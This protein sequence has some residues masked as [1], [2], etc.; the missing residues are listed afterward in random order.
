VRAVDP[1]K[2]AVMGMSCGGHQ[3]LEASLDP[4]VT[5]SVIMNS[6]LPVEIGGRPLEVDIGK[7]ILAKLHAPIAY[8]LG[9]RKDS[10]YS[11]AVD[12]FARINTIPAV[13]ANYEVGH[14][15]TYTRPNGGEFGK[16]AVAW[17]KWQL[18]RDEQAGRMYSGPSCGL[19]TDANWELEKKGIPYWNFMH[20]S[21]M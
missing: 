10:A 2:F 1:S 8:I 18:K 16:I 19:C 7:E 6:G 9:G 11:A 4:R 15:G 17:L 21:L 13:L 14:A 3:A 12:D 5:T 20:I